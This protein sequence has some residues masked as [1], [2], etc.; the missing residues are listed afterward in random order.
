MDEKQFSQVMNVLKQIRDQEEIISKKLSILIMPIF[1]RESR[2]QDK[3]ITQTNIKILD[4]CGLDY[5]EI[6]NIL[7]MSSGT[8]ANEL[9]VLRG[10]S[11]GGRNAKKD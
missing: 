5:K 3:K 11:R 7:C 1:K 9:T 8:V 6:A 10:K 2:K 4:D